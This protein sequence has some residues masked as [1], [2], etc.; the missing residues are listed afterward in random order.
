MADNEHDPRDWETGDPIHRSRLDAEQA[1]WM[2]KA[3]EYLAAT[4]ADTDPD[5]PDI[6]SREPPWGTHGPLVE[7][8]PP[9]EIDREKIEQET[10]FEVSTNL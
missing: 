4:M 1:H 2:K 9:Q 3:P 7:E 8:P 5:D 6:G 10:G